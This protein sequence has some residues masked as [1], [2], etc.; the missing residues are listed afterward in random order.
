MYQYK[1][2]NHWVIQCT[3]DR[4][5]LLDVKAHDWGFEVYLEHQDEG[6]IINEKDAYELGKVLVK[7]YRPTIKDRMTNYWNDVKGQ[8]NKYWWKLKSKFSKK[9]TDDPDD[10][11]PF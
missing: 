3:E 10:D 9:P 7:K 4:E 2:T 8:W 1:N 6:V 5:H 11:L